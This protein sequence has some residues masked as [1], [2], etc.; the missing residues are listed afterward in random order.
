MAKFTVEILV[1]TKIM[2]GLFI[3]AMEEIGFIGKL[4]GQNRK[5]KEIV[6]W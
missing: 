6:H 3:F 1:P 4:S 2:L 5:V